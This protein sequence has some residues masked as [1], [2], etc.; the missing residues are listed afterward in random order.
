MILAFGAGIVSFLSP[1]VLPLIP[2]YVSLVSK[3]SLDEIKESSTKGRLTRILF[4]CIV[5]VLGFSTVFVLLGT[6]ASFIG[7]FMLKN[8]LLLLRISG[9]AIVLFGLFVMEIFKFPSLY[10]EAR[11]HLKGGNLS[12]LSTL[13]LGIAFGL[14]WTPCVGPILASILLYAS[15]AEGAT[16]GALLLFTYSMGLGLPFILTGLA[17]SQATSAFG[18]I[19]RHYGAYKYLVGGMLV[20]VGALMAI[21]K[22]YY[23]NIYGQKLLGMIGVDF[24]QKF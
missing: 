4:P 15:T 6:G 22:I 13:L 5:F 21:N 1:C 23:L 14:G 24:W 9:V 2:G 10:R 18:W 8:K 19:K 11:F 12:L 16:K 17:L 7:G 3:L 20:V